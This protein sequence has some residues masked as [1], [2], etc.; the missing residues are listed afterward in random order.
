MLLK[1]PHYAKQSTDLMRSLSNYAW[2][3]SQ[4]RTNNPLYG[5][6]KDPE[7]PKQS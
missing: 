1:W 4:T 6:K 3:F 7:L 2:H 5:T